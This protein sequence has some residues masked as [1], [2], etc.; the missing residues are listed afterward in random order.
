MKITEMIDS[1][2]AACQTF[3]WIQNIFVNERNN[4]GSTIF[5]ASVSASASIQSNVSDGRH[6]SILEVSWEE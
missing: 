5:S 3:H 4:H 6:L 1:V 2:H